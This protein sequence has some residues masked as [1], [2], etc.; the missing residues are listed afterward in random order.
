MK[1]FPFH[2]RR[3]SR[4]LAIESIYSHE[5]TGEDI[6]KTLEFVSKEKLEYF[7]HLLEE[8]KLPPKKKDM[9]IKDLESWES[10]L[11]Y[12]KRILQSYRDNKDY[13]DKLILENLKDTDYERIHMVERAV[14]KAS[15]AELVGLGTHYRI[16]ISEAVK[17]VRDYSS[18]SAMKVVNAILDS[19][20]ESLGLKQDESRYNL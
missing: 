18:D 19:I 9:L 2:G 20:V 17:I 3:L 4:A 8:G 6:F 11:D 1:W 15:I 7:K 13:I 12:S 10:I 5:I 14:I 16:V